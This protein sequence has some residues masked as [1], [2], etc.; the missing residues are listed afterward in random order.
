M[1]GTY[2][3]SVT[4]PATFTIPDDSDAPT[5]SSVNVPIEALGDRTA[6]LKALADASKCVPVVTEWLTSGNFTL[7]ADALNYGI[8]EGCGGGG[9]GGKGG[10]SPAS[11]NLSAGGGGGGGSI[12]RS[13]ICTLYPGEQHDVNVGAGGS[14]VDG[15]FGIGVPG[16]DTELV[17]HSTV[18]KIVICEGADGGHSGSLATLFTACVA[19]AGNF[20]FARGGRPV[21]LS[22][23]AV[24]SDNPAESCPYPTMH[25]DRTPQS[26]GLGT[27]G[28]WPVVPSHG[29][30]GTTGANGS[31]SPQGFPGG[32]GGAM[33]T[34]SGGNPNMYGGG[35]GG[36]GG[37]GPFGNGGN[38]GT[39]SNG[40]AVGAS[41]SPSAGTSAA[42]NTGAGG[43]GGGGAGCAP[44]TSTVGA[45]PGDGGS[46]R[47]RL[48]YFRKMAP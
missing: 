24:T 41:A 37:A 40:V 8:Y 13:G 15:L 19:S 31:P 16:G 21:R 29:Q 39:G 7:P 1:S 48:I 26:G 12:L 33:G 2:S 38:G 43:G 30:Q 47:F 44:T 23:G 42:A 25:L 20:A 4:F 34:T 35:A 17:R 6:Y 9:A 22:A 27:C 18:A 46:G 10:V 28:T 45:S 11:D 14:G 32:L 3:G 36:G 5:A